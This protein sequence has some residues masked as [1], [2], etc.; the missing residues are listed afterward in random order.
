MLPIITGCLPKH[1][2]F[3]AHCGTIHTFP[4]QC[5]PHPH[6][7]PLQTCRG[8]GVQVMMRP[9]GPG[10]MQQIQQVC[11]QCSGKGF[12]IPPSD[13][14]ENCHGERLVSE[15]KVFEVHVDKGIRHKGKVGV[16]HAW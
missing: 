14:C 3:D 1:I 6:P 9:L 12:N 15:R 10:M 7:A 4:K 13:R 11:G 2:G 16:Q 5:H 8:T